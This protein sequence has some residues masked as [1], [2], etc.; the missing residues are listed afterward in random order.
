MC[1][2]YGEMYRYAHRP[3][4]LIRSLYYR[5]SACLCM[6][7]AILLW[8]NRPSVR[9]SVR[10]TLVSKWMHLSSNSFHRLVGT[11][12]YLKRC[13]RYKIPRGTPSP[14]ALNTQGSKN[15]FFFRQKSPFISEMVRDRP[16]ITMEYYGHQRILSSSIIFRTYCICMRAHSMRNDNQLLQRDQTIHVTKNFI[17]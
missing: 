9:P 5:A 14:G 6:Q 7:S 10:H 4:V 15:C 1:I 13:R 16:I 2:A 3:H 12:L 11:W 8:Q 17:Q